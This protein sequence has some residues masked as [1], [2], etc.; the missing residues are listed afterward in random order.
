MIEGIVISPF[1]AALGMPIRLLTPAHCSLYGMCHK[2]CD[3]Y[4]VWFSM[5]MR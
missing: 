5:P 4:K 2:G 3:K 1:C